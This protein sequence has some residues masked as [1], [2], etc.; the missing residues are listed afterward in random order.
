MLEVHYFSSLLWSF[1]AVLLSL[2]LAEL[3]APFVAAAR[4]A[5]HSRAAWAAAVRGALPALLVVGVA[6]AYE[7]DPHVP[8]MR[9][10]SWGWAVAGIAVGA[11]LVWRL[12]GLM[13]P[14]HP[15]YRAGRVCSV[16]PASPWLSS[17]PGRCSSSRWR[18]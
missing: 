3:A 15:L 12:G 10:D 13:G 7:A 16:T 11:T 8:Q 4:R 9:L 5:G 14:R 6:L 17:S 18:P 2:T 1:V